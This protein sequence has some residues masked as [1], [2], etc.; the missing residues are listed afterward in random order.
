[1][2]P[3]LRFTPLFAAAAALALLAG[4]GHYQ[5]GTTIP[6]NLRDVH[7]PNVRNESGQPGVEIELTRALIKE[8]QREG[9]L[10]IV[11]E[12]RAS[13]RLDVIVVGYRQESIRYNRSRSNVSE[14]YRMVLRAQS[15]FTDLNAI[16]PDKAILMQ[17]VREGDDTFVRG[18]DVITA[19]QR[20]LPRAA[21]E[22]AEQIVE[23]CVSAW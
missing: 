9:T 13:T 1:M 8:I 21:E 7:V 22:L 5:L 11:P 12:E 3:S 15:T 19:R 16:H 6:E 2:I 17:A 14:E 18:T 23:D 4:C 20:C 10:R